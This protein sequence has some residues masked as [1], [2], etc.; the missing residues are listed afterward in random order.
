MMSTRAWL[1]QEP[2]AFCTVRMSLVEKFWTAPAW[3]HLYGA[4]KEIST[5]AMIGNALS[6]GLA[7]TQAERHLE[8]MNLGRE[9]GTAY[10]GSLLVSFGVKRN[11]DEVEPAHNGANLIENIPEDAIKT[12]EYTLA[13]Q[14]LQGNA[15]PEK[16]GAKMT[17]EVCAGHYRGETS[18]QV[19]TEGQAIWYEAIIMKM[20]YPADWTQVPDLFIN[21]K[22]GD[23]RISYGRYNMRDGLVH[24]SLAKMDNGPADGGEI[25]GQ[26]ARW[27]DL[28]RNLTTHASDSAFPGS[29]L[30]N[31]VCQPDPESL[32]NF[33]TRPVDE[34]SVGETPATDSDE[35]DTDD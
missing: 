24:K 9:E 22:K 3:I 16:S 4:P 31:V 8:D 35:E 25:A 14:V 28:K 34:K 26:G 12:I 30:V 29:L 17:V 11:A 23:T 32:E 5:A 18:K 6:F 21:L 33:F 2:I 15:L 13:I 20:Q 10:R 7:E 27:I 1:F 19:V